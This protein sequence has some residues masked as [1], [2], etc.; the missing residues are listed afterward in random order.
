MQQR[1]PWF[2]LSEAERERRREA[3]RSLAAGFY[4]AATLN[5]MTVADRRRYLSTLD[6]VGLT[7]QA[8]IVAVDR[9]VSPGSV[10]LAWM[11]EQ[12]IESPSQVWEYDPA[13]GAAV[14]VRGREA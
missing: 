13:T 8:Q 10:I 5:A 14:L 9:N 6:E 7:R 3:A 1:G 2:H 12:T 11:V 4:S